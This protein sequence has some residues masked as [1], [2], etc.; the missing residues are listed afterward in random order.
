MSGM[1]ERT[2]QLRAALR[3]M[4]GQDRVSAALIRSVRK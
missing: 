3:V 2:R 1:R 4:R